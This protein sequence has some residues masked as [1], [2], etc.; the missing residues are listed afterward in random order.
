MKSWYSRSNIVELK[1][2]SSRKKYHLVFET[3]NKEIR[4]I[5]EKFFQSIMDEQRK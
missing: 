5:I 3:D 1:D 4:E 2:G